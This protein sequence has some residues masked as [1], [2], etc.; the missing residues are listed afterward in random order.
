M[1][2]AVDSKQYEI[3]IEPKLNIRCDVDAGI[4]ED[5]GNLKWYPVSRA[6]AKQYGTG[7]SARYVYFKLEREPTHSVRHALYAGNRYIL[8]REKSFKNKRREDDKV[9]GSSHLDDP[10]GACVDTKGVCCDNDDHWNN[11]VNEYFLC[12][13]L[14]YEFLDMAVTRGPAKLRIRPTDACGLRGKPFSKSARND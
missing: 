12:S 11:R 4:S 6:A 5:K 7:E 9:K 8:G 13:R 3:P 2:T 10:W 14:A 1:D